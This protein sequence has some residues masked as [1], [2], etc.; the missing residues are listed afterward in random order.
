MKIHNANSIFQATSIKASTNVKPIRSGQILTGEV[1]K[2]F[3][4]N[5][6]LIQANSM[7]FM[8]EAETQLVI[9]QKY[10]FQAIQKDQ[11]IQLKIL[12]NDSVKSVG[13]D[14]SVISETLIKHTNLPNTKQNQ[15][16]IYALVN[17]GIPFTESELQLMTKWINDVE[18]IPRALETIRTMIK[19]NIPFLQGSLEGVFA[20]LD[21]E[22]I[23]NQLL[24]LQKLLMSDPLREQEVLNK[25]FM[26]VDEILQFDPISQL[27][28][29]NLEGS[30]MFNLMIRNLGLTTAD[31]GALDH[32]QE[33]SLKALL[34]LSLTTIKE[35]SLL[36]ERME[37]LANRLTGMQLFTQEIGHSQQ[38]VLQLPMRLGDYLSDMT[39][40][41]NSQKNSKG[42]IDPD[43]C[44]ILFYLDLQEIGN[45]VIDMK[46]QHRVLNLTIYNKSDSLSE[47]INQLKPKLK[48][49]LDQQGYILSNVKLTV[50]KHE[51]V[52][53]KALI[54]TIDYPLKNLSGVDFL[55]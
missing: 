50:P 49:N 47:I 51:E 17:E 31:I 30:K 19:N 5:M 26:K 24:N 33:D 6:A 3:P 20:I 42:K 37:R 9:N 48:K 41:L 25:L 16:L 15:Q 22:P 45:T 34:R 28:S 14:M 39:V 12:K 27:L 7:R 55:V 44:Q 29:K 23:S 52:G 11:K 4:N 21:E 10:L 32:N 38:I 2:F 13:S 46:I 36:Y 1:V 35:G 18:D 54:S 40:Q 8:A 43:Y 53:I